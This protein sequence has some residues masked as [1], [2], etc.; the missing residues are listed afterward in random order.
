V[1]GW[2]LVVIWLMVACLLLPII[3]MFILYLA[4]A[5]IDD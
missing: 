2:E 3:A 5:P 4:G 1:P